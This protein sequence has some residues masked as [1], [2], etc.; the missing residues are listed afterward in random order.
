MSV[1]SIAS[2][3]GTIS[4]PFI[5]LKVKGR[6]SIGVKKAQLPSKLEALYKIC[7]RLY[8]NIGP[9]KSLYTEDGKLIKK[10]S[11]VTPGSTIYVSSKEGVE[12][13][14]ELKSLRT[15][16]K[17]EDLNRAKN[18]HNDA[19]KSL[20]VQQQTAKIS[21]RG[22]TSDFSDS[23]KRSIRSHK[24]LQQILDEQAK[25]R[26]TEDESEEEEEDNDETLSSVMKS[27]MGEEE[28]DI[29]SI[30]SAR[31][32]SSTSS[33]LSGKLGSM[34]GNNEDEED[35][36]DSSSSFELDPSA[37]LEMFRNLV[38]SDKLDDKLER[39]L[40]RSGSWIKRLL[41]QSPRIDEEQ[42]LRWLNGLRSALEIQGLQIPY[43]DKDG[44]E[45]YGRDYVSSYIRK[46]IQKHRFYK[47]GGA[48]YNLRIAIVGSK[49]SGK[50]QILSCFAQE[51]LLD[52]AITGTWK[53][54]F[55]FPMN[56]RVLA[57]FFNNFAAF[58]VTMVDMVL[59][60]LVWQAPTYTPHIPAIRK[61]F[62]SAV[63]NKKNSTPGVSNKSKLFVES[64]QFTTA[65][66][67]IAQKVHEL[68]ND[69]EAMPQFMTFIYLLPSLIAN[70]AGF[71]KVIFI[72][73]NLE[74]ADVELLPEP[75]FVSTGFEETTDGVSG[76]YNIEFVQFALSNQHF[77]VTG[78]AQKSLFESLSPIEES[79]DLENGI[80]FVP[81]FGIIPINDNDNT[82][83]IT[84]IQ[85][86]PI[87]LSLTIDAACGVPAFVSL[88]FELNDS[89][90]EYDQME[91][92]SD[93]K[94]D[95]LMI[96]V[97]QAQHMIDTMF[98][99]SDK[100]PLFVTTIKRTAKEQ[101]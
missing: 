92:D 39:G 88:W 12:P 95:A 14:E 89:F 100:K 74:Y 98:L 81:T 64:P 96:I 73:D 13:Q 34:L 35:E 25:N 62:I 82:L 87:P 19:F 68:Y 94:D 3:H 54:F 1:A 59:N 78:Q 24:S 16:P 99:Y 77:I 69:N 83:I 63:T 57:S 46:I 22:S 86:E 79:L 50:S 21:Y 75:P 9:V 80:E 55:I 45:L 26:L 32:L 15:P 84:E 28:E 18:A 30:K 33:K 53:Q 44:T 23:S 101:K 11:D 58:Y 71:Q 4:I 49:Q 70:A 37:F 36:F 52:L 27:L 56:F 76:I 67:K 72:I 40:F 47:P 97:T 61:L 42:M 31:R 17:Q 5:Y 85:D 43:F 65:L 41:G 29:Q 60:G 8:K 2:N 38:K 66:V 93:E 51:L 6:F 90:D 7:T 10:I 48:D 20:F 91:N